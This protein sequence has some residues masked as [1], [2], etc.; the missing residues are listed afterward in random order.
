MLLRA[1]KLL[2][3][4]CLIALFLTVS[5]FPF[6]EKIEKEKTEFI[7]EYPDASR[8]L[9]V[10]GHELHYMRTGNESGPLIVFVH[11]S[12]G[13]WDAFAEFLR[14]KDLQSKAAM[15]SI[16]RPGF[17]LSGRGQAEKSL[18]A[19]ALFISRVIEQN[20]KGA[21]VL[22]VGHSFGGPVIARI[23]MDRPD[24]VQGLLFI[25]ASVDPD[26]EIVRWYQ[27]AGDLA[28]FRWLLPEDLDTANQEILPLKGELEKL[29][30]DSIHCPVIVIQGGD[31]DLVPPG[32]ADYLGKKLPQSRM[33]RMPGWNH[34]I[35][36]AHPQQVK[37]AILDLLREK[38]L[39]HIAKATPDYFS[40][41]TRSFR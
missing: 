18:E 25:A 29:R 22:L 37:E 12:P 4:L 36:W 13:S 23:A 40:S 19:Q 8:S 41:R 31:D 2:A 5:C 14:D 38:P 11:G 30:W 21:R 15:I 3:F 24:L 26:L 34:F 33:I 6:F 17:G 9:R 27:R 35:P 10:S 32:N 16:D 39:T 20:R 7:R 1:R 28:L